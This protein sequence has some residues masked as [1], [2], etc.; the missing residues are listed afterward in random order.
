MY[1]EIY[2][3]DRE[4]ELKRIVPSN[5]EYWIKEDEGDFVWIFFSSVQI[6]ELDFQISV[7]KTQAIEKQK[8]VGGFIPE[9]D[10][11][12]DHLSNDDFSNLI[13][14]CLYLKFYIE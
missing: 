4:P 14:K 9:L 2:T 6:K 12:F 7:L 5:I 1:P 10:E 8:K 13:K 11:V 3:Y